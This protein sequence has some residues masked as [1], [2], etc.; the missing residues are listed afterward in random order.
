MH[1]NCCLPLAIVLLFLAGG[2][3]AADVGE[4]ALVEDTDGSINQSI[5]APNVYLQKAACA[6]YQTH[7]DAFNALLVFTSIPQNTMTNVQQGWPVKQTQKGIGR[8]RGTD[9]T[10]SFCS[11]S[12]RL[13]QAVK[14]G[15]INKL[16]ANP[17]DPYTG[18]LW[19]AL[20]GIELLGHEFGHHWMASITFQKDDGAR[21]C[22]LR[23]FEPS[24]EPQAGACDGYDPNSFNQHWSYYFNSGS[25][26]YGSM[27]ED[28][29]GGNFRLSYNNPKY[30][31]LDQYLMGLR[32]ATEVPAQFLIDVGDVAGS[33]SASMPIQPGQTRDETGTRMDFTIEDI[34][35]AEGARVPE[36]DPCHWK[37][38]FLI[39]H[40][41][42]TPPTAAEIA[43]VEAYRQRWEEFYAW[44]TDQRGSFD[45]TLAGTGP[46]TA[47]CPAG[48][49]PDGGSDAG[50][51]AGPPDAGSDSGTD[52]GADPGVDSG[53][54]DAGAD[55]HLDGGSDPGPTQDTGGS[56]PGADPGG[57]C[58]CA[59]D[60]G[61]ALAWLW[62][63]GLA[64]LALGGA[65]L[66]SRAGWSRR[67]G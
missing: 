32:T 13:R 61:S 34:I 43:Q 12:G 9:Q 20:S 60:S 25:L 57:G 8:D 36:L 29:G 14:M 37:G 2:A 19:Y 48:A 21:H 49:Q 3:R 62:L 42:G 16:P 39:V 27:I 26:M 35:R 23:G 18:I 33:G 58:G 31:P 40:A 11:P 56:D 22:L 7:P 59:T 6:F 50:T 1:R 53:P 17:D 52:T 55:A 41:A 45:T 66:R 47:G 46:G 54:A 51:D 30:A 65:L 10:A 15:D 24:G 38:A 5:F 28:L 44:A 67:A 4:I 63:G 64:G